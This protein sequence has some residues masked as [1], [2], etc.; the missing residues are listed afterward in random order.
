MEYTYTVIIPHRNSLNLL[1][2][3]VKSIPDRDDIQTIV[4]DNSPSELNFDFLQKNKT[5]FTLLFSDP[6]AGAGHARNVGLK[7]ARGKWILFLDADDFYNPGA[8]DHFDKYVNSEY[9]IIYFSTTS[10]FTDTKEKAERNIIYTKL[11]SD[12]KNG[13][14]GADDKLRYRF[15]S[16]WSKLIRRQLI[17]K[18]RIEFDE[19]PASND[20]MFSIKSG[21][22]A[23]KIWADSFPAY[24]VTI[25]KGSLTRTINRTNS[26][27]RYK[28][29]I[30]Q[31]KF[32]SK[33]GKPNFRFRLMSTVL[34]SL[35]F[36]PKELFWYI[37][38][39]FKE[40]VNIFL[41]FYKYPVLIYRFFLENIKK[42]RDKYTIFEN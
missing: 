22:F 16:P 26:R 6:T 20:L 42:R 38:V 13:K 19:I 9:D 40:R 1:K 30:S 4:I 27:S 37:S 12:F 23:K 10:V 18:N 33:V 34:K 11:I 36:G 41:G 7:D 28:A 15:V 14:K 24:C 5:N 8:F 25:N 35:K 31:Y 2:N 32:M 17:E 3:A 29:Y 21:H 39:A